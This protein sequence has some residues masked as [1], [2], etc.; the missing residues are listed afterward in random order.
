MTVTFQDTG[1]L[2][3]TM[4]FFFLNSARENANVTIYF[5]KFTYLIQYFVS[6]V[7]IPIWSIYIVSL[8][9]LLY[10]I[11]RTGIQMHIVCRTQTS[12]ADQLT[13]FFDNN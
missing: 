10:N 9:F 13:G 6:V 4:I 7:V 5:L 2:T 8:F 12:D 1:P 11:I 3:L